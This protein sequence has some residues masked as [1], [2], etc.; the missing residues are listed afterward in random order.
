MDYGAPIFIVGVGR[1][2]TS[3]LQSM[4]ASHPAL[5]LPPETGFLRRYVAHG[6]LAAIA[7]RLDAD[8]VARTLAADSRF[9]RVG[10]DAG[11]LVARTRA[12][13]DL[14]DANLYRAMLEMY[15]ESRGTGRFGD[16]DPRAV[17]HLQDIASVYPDAC[18]LHVIRDPR[19]VLVSKSRASWSRRRSWPLHVVAN[20]AQLRIGRALGPRLFGDRY[21]EV[22]YEHLIEDPAAVLSALCAKLGLEFDARM[23]EYHAAARLLMSEEERGWKSETA[24]P[25]LSGNREKWRRELSAFRTVVTERACAEAM[26]AGRYAWSSAALRLHERMMAPIMVTVIAVAGDLHA[27]RRIRSRPAA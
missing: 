7:R 16:K 24:G 17:E 23:L 27:R 4:L 21:Q 5:S 22:V 8:A 26:S 3:L 1:S 20:R 11:A 18:V 19:D 12:R 13:G 14:T 25:L 6:R 9:R 10:I 15:A 2:G